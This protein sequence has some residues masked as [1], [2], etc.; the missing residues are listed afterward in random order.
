MVNKVL[1]ATSWTDW[2]AHLLQLRKQTRTPTVGRSAKGQEPT[3]PSASARRHEWVFGF[4]SE[5]RLR[6]LTLVSPTGAGSAGSDGR[7]RRP[8][9]RHGR[10]NHSQAARC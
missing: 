3:L 8:L 6:L 9:H 1:I 4:S 10:W 2:P 7:T 5:L